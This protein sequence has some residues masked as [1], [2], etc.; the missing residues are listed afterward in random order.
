MA[1]RDTLG[2]EIGA[3][4]GILGLLLV[5]LPLFVQAAAD[6]AQGKE[7]QKERRARIRQAW[8][9]PLLIGVAAV[10]GTLGLLSLWGTWRVASVTGWLLIALMWLV[11]GL[12]GWAVKTGVR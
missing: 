4:F 7:P 11:V 8:G 6:A 5:F 1:A 12:S 2:V 10:D 3:A 9:V